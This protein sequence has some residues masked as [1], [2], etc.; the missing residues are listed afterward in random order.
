MHVLFYDYFIF[1]L[2]PIIPILVIQTDK[3]PDHNLNTLTIIS[4]TL[5]I[6]CKLFDIL[7]VI[8][9]LIWC[10]LDDY[11]MIIWWLLCLLVVWSISVKWTTHPI[12]HSPDCAASN[13][14]GRACTSSEGNF[15]FAW[16]ITAKHAPSI[17]MLAVRIIQ[18]LGCKLAITVFALK[19]MN[20][21]VCLLC[22][23]LVWR[24]IGN[25]SQCNVSVWASLFQF[26][27]VTAVGNTCY[28][29]FRSKLKSKRRNQ[30]F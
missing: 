6:I 30:W 11:L 14:D 18:M 23:W 24:S 27:T 10:S 17:S 9:W 2:T 15:W 29:R 4:N 1:Y 22:V 28:G 25:L 16:F 12:L 5:T 26:G 13:S 21:S 19:Y 3:Y 20:L 7:W 8:I